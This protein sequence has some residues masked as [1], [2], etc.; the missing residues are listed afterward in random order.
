MIEEL[1]RKRLENKE[2]NNYKKLI[3]D[4]IDLKRNKPVK[5][6]NATIDVRNFLT[7]HYTMIGYNLFHTTTYII[8][9]NFTYK[10]AMDYEI[11][12]TN[13]KKMTIND[14]KKDL[15]LK[16]ISNILG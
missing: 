16:K 13:R 4:Y 11:L 8:Y 10:E 14:L 15:R 2:S 3:D 12:Y 5:Y 1:V 9:D 7:K 6:I